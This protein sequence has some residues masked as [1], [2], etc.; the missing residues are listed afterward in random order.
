MK[1][2]FPLITL[3]AALAAAPALAADYT[4]SQDSTLGFRATYMDDRFEGRFADFTPAIR[5][6]PADLPSSRFDVRIALSSASTDN[7]ERDE[8]LVGP[9]FFNAGALP[10]ARYQADRFTALGGSRFRA[11]GRLTLNGVSKPVALEFDWTPGTP[12]VLEGRASLERLAFKV[13]EGDWAD[14]DLLPN[15]VE[16]FTRLEL[17]PKP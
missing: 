2:V 13:G 3:L 5:F 9:E 8:L 6:D 1:S 17:Q 12:A 10:E 4:A 7:Q 11:D 14:T 15:K 16:V